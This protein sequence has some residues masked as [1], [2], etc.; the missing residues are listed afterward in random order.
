LRLLLVE[1]SL[2]QGRFRTNRVAAWANVAEANVPTDFTVTDINDTWSR[3]EA[4]QGKV[5]GYGAD[6][7]TRL[8]LDTKSF[9][10]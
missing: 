10:S 2:T 6:Y 5:K 4:V 7:Y 3:V 8:R 1:M 9:G